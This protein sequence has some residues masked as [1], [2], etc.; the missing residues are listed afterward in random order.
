[1]FVRFFWDKKA[2]SEALF[3]PLKN[4]K[5]KEELQCKAG[6]ASKFNYLAIEFRIRNNIWRYRS[7]LAIDI[8]CMFF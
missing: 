8:F 2:T 6:S 4:N 7:E 1:M 3:M 5:D